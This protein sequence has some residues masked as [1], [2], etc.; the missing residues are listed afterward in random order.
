MSNNHRTL[1]LRIS[2]MTCASCSAVISKR[3]GENPAITEASIN[4]ASHSARIGYDQ[5]KIDKE[6][7]IGIIRSAGYDASEKE[8]NENNQDEQKTQIQKRKNIFIESALLGIPLIIFGLGPLFG[9]DLPAVPGLF[10]LTIQAFFALAIMAIN[11]PVYTS[12]LTKLFRLHPNMD[13]LV[14]IGT[15]AAFSY[16]FVIMIIGLLSNLETPPVYFDSAGVILIFVALGRWLEVRA[17]SRASEA[18]RK[19]AKLLPDTVTIENKGQEKKVSLKDARPGDIMIV[20]AGE[21]IA[22]DGIIIEGSASIDESAISG[23]SLPKDKGL[24]AEIIG[25]T[26]NKNGY[27]KARISRRAEDTMLAQIMNIVEQAINSKAPIQLLADRVSYYFV[28]AVIIIAI[29]S[30]MIWLS[31]GA[32]FAAALTAFVSVLIIACPCSLG[33]ATPT[34]IMVG[35]GLAAKQGI[36]IKNAGALEIAGRIDTIVFDKTGTLTTGELEVQSLTCFD[37]PENKV[38][39]TAYNLSRRSDHPLSK[40]VSL[41]CQERDTGMVDLPDFKE[42]IGRGLSAICPGGSGAILLGNR[43][44]MEENDIAIADDVTKRIE[45][46]AQAGFTPLLV[47]H[48]QRVVGLL[49]IMDKER[50]DAKEAIAALK[51][52]EKK[53]VIISGDTSASVRTIAERLGIDE[54]F[55]EVIPSGKAS[56]IEK[57]RKEGRHVAMVGDGINDAPALARADIGIAMSGGSDIAK[58]SGDI[59]LTS[60]RLKSIEE[61]ISI[62]ALTMRKIKQNLFWAFLYNSAGIPI[63]AGILYPIWGITLNPMIGALAMALSSVSVVT[64]SLSM[65]WYH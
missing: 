13:S 3:L 38:L 36:L 1:K 4:L 2:G 26:I 30:S 22:L 63:A 62:S 32:G 16:S 35:S 17:T 46:S 39:M 51:A 49:D 20:K 60:T 64:N 18:I 58:E 45:E 50:N 53:V 44:L 57:L 43:R 34:A 33:L 59:L 29:T 40:A 21:S 12:G 55:A 37:F 8:E 24:G 5:D 14:A 65:K 9:L 48:D 10:K 56:I 15:G 61:A 41:F 27:L 47:A 52:S 42:N 25:G 6:V 11:Y 7:I 23:E 28:P 54:F 31:A 19:L